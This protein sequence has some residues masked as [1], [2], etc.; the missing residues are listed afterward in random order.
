MVSDNKMLAKIQYVGLVAC[1]P[2]N[3]PTDLRGVAQQQPA[4]QDV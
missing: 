4:F 3:R 1:R 2:M